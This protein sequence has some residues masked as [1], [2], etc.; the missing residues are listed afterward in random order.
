M[1]KTVSPDAICTILANPSPES[2]SDLPEIVVQV[3]DL[4]PTG[5]RYMLVLF[6]L[7]FSY[8]LRSVYCFRRAFLLYI[9]Y[10]FQNMNVLIQ[11]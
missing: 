6:C 9:L 7:D 5:N 1:A 2:S 10:K 3:L 11:I 8:M 4:K